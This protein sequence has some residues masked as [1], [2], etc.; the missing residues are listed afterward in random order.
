MNIMKRNQMLMAYVKAYIKVKMWGPHRTARTLQIEMLLDNLA[1]KKQAQ[2]KIHLTKT[3]T[4]LHEETEE[5]AHILCFI[6]NKLE[7]NHKMSHN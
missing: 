4:W 3:M 5:V 2:E 7:A 1:N 6:G